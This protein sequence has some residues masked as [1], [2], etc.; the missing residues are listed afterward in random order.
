MRFLFQTEKCLIKTKKS[1]YLNQMIQYS[2]QIHSYLLHKLWIIWRCSFESKLCAFKIKWQHFSHKLYF[3]LTEMPWFICGLSR[4]KRSE[5]L[6][7][8]QDGTEHNAW[9]QPKNEQFDALGWVGQ[10]RNCWL[11]S[12]DVCNCRTTPPHSRSTHR[13][14]CSSC[15]SVGV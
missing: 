11:Y 3:Y 2:V 6:R 8:A 9:N 10:Q 12:N 5:L 14:A 15:R 4:R 1:F 7:S 13:T